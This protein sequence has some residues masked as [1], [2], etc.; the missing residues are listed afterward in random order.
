MGYGTRAHTHVD[1]VFVAR[2]VGFA[3]IPVGV[4]HRREVSVHV[5]ALLAYVVQACDNMT[6]VKRGS[7]RAYADKEHVR[8]RCAQARELRTS[9]WAGLG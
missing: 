7:S 6:V 1:T 4:R 3:G 8:V 9:S 2:V 5:D